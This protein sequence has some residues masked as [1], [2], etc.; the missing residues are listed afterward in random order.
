LLEIDKVKQN[1]FAVA[2]AGLILA[3]NAAGA[4][5]TVPDAPQAQN[6]AQPGTIPDAPKPQTIPSLSNVAPGIGTTSTS[7]GDG[8]APADSSADAPHLTD[9]QKKVTPSVDDGPAPEQGIKAFSLGHVSVNFVQTPFIVKDSKGHLVS[10]IDWREV[11][12]YENGVRQRMTNF[13][14][15]PFPLSVA[16]VID[17]SVPFDT[18]TKVNN[19]LS[20]LQG[21]FTP[22]DSIAIF[23][24]NNGP[25][26]QTDFTGAQS[27]RVTAILERSKGKGREP[28][29]GLTGPLSQ[30]TNI[31]N[32][33][34]DMNTAPVRNNPGMVLNAPKELHTLN[35]AILEAAVALT[36]TGKDR[37]R[38]IYVISDGKEYGSKAKFKDVIHY[39]QAHEIQVDGTIVGDSAMP[40]IGFLDRYHL[41]FQMRD[42]ILPRYAA[43]TGGQ[44][45]SEN[46]T[47]GIEES[48]S[49]ITKEV[50]YQYTVG[51]YTHEPFIDGKY[52]KTEVRVLRPSL[53]VI[54][55][56][57]YYPS[58]VDAVR[59][60]APAATDP[61]A[62]SAPPP[63]N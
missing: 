28:I 9:P 46:R 4:Q 57:G 43:A 35:D 59:P 13:T 62:P 48:F 55:R 42:D 31:N 27:A 50:R 56:D 14:S 47:G 34:F 8:S 12:I 32:T 54:S 21:A 33:Q 3:Q 1:V 39:L 6:Q 38:V 37:R 29:M 40:I 22:Y 2:L 36:K 25:Q 15:D 17:Q 19:A 61:P 52:R 10:G 26:M 18:M 30:T 24:Y 45:A 5:Q 23:T 7:N 16:L 58:A 20:A 53:T 49:E 41:P 63:T 60:T 51:Y 44:M 11:R